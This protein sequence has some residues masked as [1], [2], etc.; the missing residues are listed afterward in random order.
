L[1]TTTYVI[2]LEMLRQRR[3]LSRKALCKT[4]DL[5]LSTYSLLLSTPGR[6]PLKTT[7]DKLRMFFGDD[8]PPTPV[9]NLVYRRPK[10]LENLVKYGHRAHRK[11]AQKRAAKTRKGKP[12]VISAIH[13]AAISVAARERHRKRPELGRRLGK[14]QQSF[15]G[16]ALTSLRLRLAWWNHPERRARSPRPMPATRA[17]IPQRSE[18]R[19]WA[20][21]Y[22][23]Q[24]G[25]AQADVLQVWKPWLERVGL[26][27]RAGRRRADERFDLITNLMAGWRRT[28]SGKL[29]RGFWVEVERAVA[30][31]EGRQSPD[32]ESLKVFYHL[33]LSG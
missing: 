9:A 23:R 32:A 24:S 13:R 30:R 19:T 3:R 20:L 6:V 2:A 10:A 5:P 21:E 7:D 33:H 29:G 8:L 11:V 28:P 14:F 12:Q 4:I 26:W 22:A 25:A 18:I 16:R 27:S 31:V 1:N 15:D 17:Q